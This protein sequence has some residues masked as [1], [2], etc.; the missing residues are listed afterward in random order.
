MQVL[1]L[2]T[3]G[4]YNIG[5]ELLLETFLGQLGCENEFF[6][7]SY[8]PEF[9]KCAL[10]DRYNVTTFHTTKD[11]P[12][13]ISYL[14]RCDVLVFGGGSIIKEL[15]A[16]VGRNRY[17]TLVMIFCVVTFA[18]LIARKRVVLSNIGV[19]PISTPT[20]KQIARWILGQVDVLSVRDQKSL[21]TCLQLG[22]AP[23]QVRQVPDAVFVNPP[24]VF[25]VNNIPAHRDGKLHIA[26]N[27][28]YDIET[29]AAW[30]GFLKS[31]AEALHMLNQRQRLVV[32]ALP[33]Q[34][35]FKKNDDLY[36]LRAFTETLSGIEI[37]IHDPQTAQEAAQII[38]GVDLVLAERL[39]TIIIASIIG[40]AVFGLAY[41][42]KVQELL[43]ILD[44]TQYSVNI[45]EPIVVT[46][47]YTGLIYLLDHREE[48]EKHLLEHSQALRE[49][50]DQYFADLHL[51]LNHYNLANTG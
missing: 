28:N 13:F 14:L 40:K 6:I 50:L 7:N 23:A 49:E 32:H 22:I 44:I 24:Q 15:Y 37:Q 8:D 39:H 38:A 9:T 4:Q 35:R 41:D 11:M 20:G 29:R 31:L 42:V 43:Q 26:L 51:Q 16:S 2:G 18:H 12:R 34:S 10:Q 25:L 19:G 30:E 1:F 36:I 33:M 27:L 5:D 47:L 46:N 21:Q 3:H 45:N 17:A 48:V